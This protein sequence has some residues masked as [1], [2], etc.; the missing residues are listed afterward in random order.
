MEKGIKKDKWV[1]MPHAGHLIVS[2]KCRFHLNTKVGKYIIST[3]GEYWPEREVRE[4][5]AKVYDLKWLL[6]NKHLL[7]DNFDNAYIKRF[8]FV[9][10]GCDRT[11]ETMVFKA[12]KSKYKCCP[13]VA[14]SWRELDMDGYKTA[15]DAYKGHL[16][17]CK[18]WA[19]KN[20]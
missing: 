7:G 8:G 16:K 11:Y 3:V 4:I 20:L 9:E 6:E 17:M 5:H 12:N 14:A 18:K 1:W 10:I 2:D 19:N 15:E 13:Y